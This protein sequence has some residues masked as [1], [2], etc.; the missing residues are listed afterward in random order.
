MNVH[1]NHTNK[2]WG[3]LAQLFAESANS[4]GSFILRV[5]AAGVR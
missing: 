4:L 5:S 2:L 3:L 1:R